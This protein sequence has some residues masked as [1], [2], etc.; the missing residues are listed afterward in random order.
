M[1]CPYCG[2]T[3]DKTMTVCPQ[4]RAAVN[5]HKDEPKTEPKKARKNEV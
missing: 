4:C 1:K 2:T 3:I 5:E